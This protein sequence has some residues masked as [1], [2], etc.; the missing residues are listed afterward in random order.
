MNE[1]ADDSLPGKRSIRNPGRLSKF[2][3]LGEMKMKL[4]KL[5]AAL[6]AASAMSMTAAPAF[7]NIGDHAAFNF[8]LPAT[9]S[10][11]SS[12]QLLASL[13]L[14]KTATGVN[15]TLTPN[16][17]EVGG[18]GFNS[19]SHIDRLDLVYDGLLNQRYLSK[20]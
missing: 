16:W 5:V 17:S 11:S 6:V 14:T 13:L 15:F 19:S 20:C 8:D 1:V 7:A 18:A 4:N 2:I 12:Y 10:W 3:I 9:G